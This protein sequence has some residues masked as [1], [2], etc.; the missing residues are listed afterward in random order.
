MGTTS[1]QLIDQVLTPY[2]GF[3]LPPLEA[4]ACGAP[5]ACSNTSSM[6]EVVGDAALLFNPLDT[7]EMAAACRRILQDGSLR[8]NLSALSLRQAARFSWDDCAR[9]TLEVYR[10]IAVLHGKTGQLG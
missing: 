8:A 10:S 6:P 4:M 9:A 1:Q 7:R 2:E 5:V 3:G